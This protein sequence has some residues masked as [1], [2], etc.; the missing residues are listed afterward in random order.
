MFFL[1][2]GK[3][4]LVVPHTH[5]TTITINITASAATAARVE[6]RGRRTREHFEQQVS[7]VWG[8][9]AARYLHASAQH[10]TAHY[11]TLQQNAAKHSQLAHR[12]IVIAV[13]MT[14]R[15]GDGDGDGD[16]DVMRVVRQAQSVHRAVLCW[17]MPRTSSTR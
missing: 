12:T 15:P 7:K 2:I 16:G 13:A 10:I 6:G 5:T 14:L 3:Q 17:L 8:E 4:N 11:S 1:H 9:T